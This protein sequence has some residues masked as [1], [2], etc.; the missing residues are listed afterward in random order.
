[1]KALLFVSAILVS[2]SSLAQQ[3]FLPQAPTN[4]YLDYQKQFDAWR[5]NIDE[6][7]KGYKWHMR[8]LNYAETRTGPYGKSVSS[9]HYLEAAAMN[10]LQKGASFG[11]RASDSTW[12]PEGP[13]TLTGAYN[14][15]SSHGVSRVNT[16][17]FHPTDTNTYWV[18]VSQG[19]IWKTTNSGK[20][21]F[22]VNDGL[23]ILRISDIAVDKN[24][25]DTLYA[26]VCDYAYI[27]VAL[28][29]DNRK[30]NTHYG[31]GLY[32]SYDGG[33]TWNPTGLTYQQNQYDYTLIRRTF[34]NSNNAQELICAGVEGI[35][36]SF[37]GGDTWSKNYNGLIW[38]FEQNPKN[39]NTIYAS[40]G[41]LYN[42]G[43][44]EPK[45]MV[46]H[47][48]GDSWKTIG[49]GQ[50]NANEA[51]SRV[52]ITISSLD[53]NY[54]YAVSCGRDRGLFGFY[55]STDAGNTWTQT[56]NAPSGPNILEWSEGR[57]SGGQG[58]YDLTIYVDKKDKEKV[59]V[60][61][62]N[63]WGSD[64]GG[65]TWDGC[66]YWLRYYGFTP[67]ADQHFLTHNPLDNKYYLCND[68]GIFRTDSMLIGSWA[69]ANNVAGYEFPT[70]WQ[71]VSSGMQITSLYRVGLCDSVPGYIV[72]GA[73][74]NG[75]FYRDDKGK[76]MNISGGDGMDAV[77]HR[78]DPTQGISSSQF[79][80]FYEFYNNGSVV[81]NLN[82][83]ISGAGGWTT[84]IE[85]SPTTPGE[86]Y[87]GT[88]NVTVVS[89]FAGSR[90]LGFIPGSSN[91]PISA[92]AISG[93]NKQHLIAAKR[94]YFTNNVNTK[95]YYTDDEGANWVDITA[96]LP[97]SMYCTAVT[98]D[99]RFPNIV[100]A[101]FGGFAA[102]Q[103]VFRSDDSGKTWKNMSK[104]LPDVPVNTIVQDEQ[105]AANT[106]YVGCDV[107]V[108]YTN[109]SLANWQLYAKSFP[110]VIVS[111]LEV[112]GKER[113]LYASTFGRGIWSVGA[114]DSVYVFPEDTTKKEDTVILDPEVYVSEIFAKA[115]FNLYP[116]PNKGVFS[117]RSY[118]DAS[119][120]VDISIV[121]VM[122]RTVFEQTEFIEEGAY[123]LNYQLDLAD[124]VYFLR[125]NGDGKSKV[126][127][128][129]VTH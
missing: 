52:E 4:A 32:K 94:P 74:D 75:T 61:G 87:I 62:V 102:G 8:W 101:T 81:T 127:R 38:D 44:G 43:I 27:G 19:G 12:V 28:S 116:N 128:F 82:A 33:L 48:F 16:I 6:N 54:L 47:D 122:G 115:Q 17:T 72:S 9:K 68:G 123:L 103:K 1:M 59:F 95:L 31:A 96:G 11:S 13:D 113:R 21:Y 91:E 2:L 129:L 90:Q 126:Q 114:L 49:T 99:D 119:L 109:D 77:I 106:V 117:I 65:Q 69:D 34:V 42:L 36:K 76:W 51:M 26:S 58:T 37:D 78:A 23:P 111:D 66:S 98:I 86:Y 105:S 125:V 30:R 55:K 7:Q 73:Q 39:P 24:H 85:Q 25:P 14:A 124:G 56:I 93:L 108:Y 92:F 53:T 22:P 46:S 20:T 50:F 15:A 18:G 40:S 41:Y 118:S 3:D 107:G 97:D 57:G 29:T 110:N 10:S 67:H 84:P 100:W 88:T 64:D 63:L 120:A 5:Q 80:R 112:H 83:S 60:G 45:M 35:L 121:N 104:N 89:R 71:D 70:K 79:G